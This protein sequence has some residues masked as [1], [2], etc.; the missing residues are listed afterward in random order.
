MN[1]LEAQR[2]LLGA[3]FPRVIFDVGSQDGR[4]TVEYLEAFQNATLFS[5]E[6]ED[7]NFQAASRTLQAYGNRVRLYNVAVSERAG[8]SPLFINSHYGSHSLL[9]VGAQRFWGTYGRTLATRNVETVS[10]DQVAD[11]NGIDHIDILKMDIQ[12]GELAALRGAARLLESRSIDVIAIEVEFQELYRGQPLIWEIGALLH[13]YAY[14]MYGLFD[15]QYSS[16]NRNVLCWADAIFL[17]PDLLK[18]AEG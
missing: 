4:T 17:S 5:F 14:G 13:G 10:L 7:A 6:P 3:T 2:S 8:T 15:C 18:V 11:A 1:L 12:G 9:P 16:K